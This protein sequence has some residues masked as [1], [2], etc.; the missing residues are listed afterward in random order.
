MCTCL[1]RRGVHKVVSYDFMLDCPPSDSFSIVIRC[2]TCK[3]LQE[4]AKVRMMKKKGSEK[5]ESYWDN[6]WGDRKDYTQTGR[7]KKA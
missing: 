6:L 2:V 4:Q 1:F 5:T 7:K 3:L